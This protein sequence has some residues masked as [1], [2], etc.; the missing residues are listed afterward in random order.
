[1]TSSASMHAT[2]TAGARWWRTGTAVRGSQPLDQLRRARDEATEDADRLR[3]RPDLDVDPSVQ[4]EMVDGPGA[5]GP[6]HPGR[7]RVVDH[8]DRAA[9]LGDLDERRERRDVAVHREHAV[10][11]QQ[12]AAARP[13]SS[14]RAARPRDPASRCSNTLI[15]AR[16]SRAPSMIEAWFSRSLTITSSFPGRRRRS[17]SSP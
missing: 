17:R 2:T 13:A 4:T 11:D 8:H 12:L 5:P 16:D 14:R 10:G 1:M 6:E 15:S 9:L 3:Q 7:M